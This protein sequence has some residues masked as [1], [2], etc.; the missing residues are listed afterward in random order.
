MSGVFFSSLFTEIL[1]KASKA[2]EIQFTEDGEWQPMNSKEEECWIRDSPAAVEAMPGSFQSVT[3]S[4]SSELNA[5]IKYGISLS[6]SLS[7]VE[8][9]RRF[10]FKL[11]CP[12]CECG[13][14]CECVYGMYGC[15]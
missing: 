6:A 9:H 11:V 13:C 1:Q 2:V 14:V 3:L 4:S 15:L 10:Y 8:D 5:I 12:V 7:S